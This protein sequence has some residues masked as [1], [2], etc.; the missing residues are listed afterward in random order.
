[1][2]V[3]CLGSGADIK[4]IPVFINVLRETH[5]ENNFIFFCVALIWSKNVG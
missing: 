3:P 4:I 1:M 2:A 5:W